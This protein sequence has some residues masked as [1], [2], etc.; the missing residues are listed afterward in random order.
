MKTELEGPE[1]SSLRIQLF[2]LAPRRWG[3]GERSLEVEARR[4]GCIRRLRKETCTRKS[5]RN[6]TFLLGEIKCDV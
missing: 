6:M 4:N 3:R 1:R 5:D 2:L